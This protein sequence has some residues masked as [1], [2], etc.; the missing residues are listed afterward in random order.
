MTVITGTAPVAYE[1]SRKFRDA[2]IPVVL[3]GPHVTL[4]PEDPAP[5][6]DAI[7]VGYAEETRPQ[8]LRDF[9]AGRMRQ[10]YDQA[11]DFRLGGYP[12]V[13]RT[14]FNRESL[15]HH[16][17]FSRPHAAASHDCDFC[18]VPTPA[19]GTQ[20]PLPEAGRA[21]W[22]RI[23]QMGAKKRAIFVDLNLIADLRLRR[24]LFDRPDPAE[25]SLVRTGD[26]DHAWDDELLDLAGPQRLSRPADR[27]GI[28]APRNRRCDELRRKGSTSPRLRHGHP[29]AAR[30]DRHHGLLRVRLRRRHAEVFDET[31]EF[32]VEAADRP[33]AFA[34]ITPFPGTALYRRLQAAKAAS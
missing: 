2:G 14:Y 33:A 16:A 27:I 22:S 19:W 11:P 3:G 25:A 28:G 30:P 24:E 7:V 10:R 17:M 26:D 5:H 6:A 18:V 8:L 23:R 13:D 31:A 15:H 12:A 20:R 4:V 29:R 21:R 32:A 1:L 9:S 34:I